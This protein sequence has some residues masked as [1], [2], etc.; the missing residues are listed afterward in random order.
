MG[1]PFGAGFR[2]RNIIGA[3]FKVRN[4]RKEIL[5]PLQKAVIILKEKNK[6]VMTLSGEY[7]KVCMYEFIRSLG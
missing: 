6:R 1:S 4:I 5:F 2:V 7:D 3:G